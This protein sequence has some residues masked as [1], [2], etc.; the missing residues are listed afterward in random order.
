MKRLLYLASYLRQHSLFAL[1]TV[2]RHDSSSPSAPLNL[3][4]YKIEATSSLTVE[5]WYQFG[6]AGL[7]DREKA[8]WAG[9]GTMYGPQ[10]QPIL[11]IE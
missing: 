10:R 7:G 11:L 5:E 8:T 9:T 2:S 3:R 1:V 4:G 6:F